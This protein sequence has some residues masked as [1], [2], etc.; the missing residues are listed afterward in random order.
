MRQ[1][2]HSVAKR[3]VQQAIRQHFFAAVVVGVLLRLRRRLLRV[4]LRRV[5]LVV[6]GIGLRRIGLVLVRLALR[7]VGGRRRGVV[8]GLV[9]V[10]S[11]RRHR[12]RLLRNCVSVHYIYTAKIIKRTIKYY[13]LNLN[14]ETV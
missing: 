14:I 13:F 1:A 2:A 7:N 8:D 6:L 4:D 10:R 9:G 12:I 11:W 5:L 3:H